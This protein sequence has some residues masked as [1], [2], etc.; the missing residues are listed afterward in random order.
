MGVESVAESEIQTFYKDKTVF[1]TGGSGFLGKVIIEKLL[2]STKVKRI[3]VLIRCKRG[4]DG[5]QRIADWKNNAMFSLLL[6]S[7]ASCFNRISPINGD[8]LDAK[9]GISQADMQLLTDEVQVVVHSAASVRFMEP[10]HLAVD[11]NT[12]STRLMLQLAKRMPRLEAYVH[13]S[14]AYSNCVIEHINERFYPENLTCTAETILALREQLSDELFDSMKPALIGKY[15][16]TYTFTKALAEE[17]VQTEGSGLPISIFR[18]GVIIGSY[19]DPLPGWVDNLYGPMGLIIGC[20]LGVVRV[21]FI[22]RLA[23]AHVVPVD[24][25]VN[26]L[27][28]SAGRTARDHATCNKNALATSSGA[29]PQLP[30]IYNYV[31][32]DKNK[33]TWGNFIDCSLKL[34]DTYPLS[35]MMWLP[36][37]YIVSTTWIFNLIAFLVHIVPGYFIDISLRLRGQKPRMIKIYQKIHE[38]IDVVKPFVTQS[39]HFATHNTD[40]L[41]KSLSPQDQQIFE[42]DMGSVDWSDYFYRS[43][44]GVRIHLG[45]EVNTEEN[46][47]RARNIMARYYILHRL[48]QFVLWSGVA[49]I[50]WRLIKLFF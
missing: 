3:Y 45:K 7:D 41:W 20:A 4:Q 12:R 37:V 26:M 50:L 32:S 31:L 36:C 49:A 48:L 29:S 21:L 8:C 10:L 16:N 40:K 28:A 25:C 13:V 19:K 43:L 24:Y 30:V 5:L 11:I 34:V 42:F 27:L 39:F 2:R 46:I 22:N 35:K 33:F 17:V 38:N 9:L 44:G 1:L 23:L 47:K 6:Q 18:P 14:T 15:P